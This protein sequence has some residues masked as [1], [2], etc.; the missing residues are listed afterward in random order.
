VK[1]RDGSDRQALWVKKKK[2]TIQNW[3]KETANAKNDAMKPS[4][5]VRHLHSIPPAYTKV[6]STIFKINYQFVPDRVGT[7]P[8]PGDRRSKNRVICGDT[9]SNGTN[10]AMKPSKLV[11][12]LYS[13]PPAYKDKYD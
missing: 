4:K 13:I 10:D 2:M 5:Q 6:W 8:E 3:F 12:H 11:C 9:F 1:E 7:N